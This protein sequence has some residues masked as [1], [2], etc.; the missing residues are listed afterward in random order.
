MT[1]F[2][3]LNSAVG[4]GIPQGLKPLVILVLFDTTEVV[5]F[6]HSGHS[7][8][9]EVVPFQSYEFFRSLPVLTS[10]LGIAMAVLGIGARWLPATL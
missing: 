10:L 4:R 2:L 8:A 9:T 6:Q 5:P 7:K 1:A 3:G